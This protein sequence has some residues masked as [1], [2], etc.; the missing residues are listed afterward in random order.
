[1]QPAVVCQQHPH[2]PQLFLYSVLDGAKHGLGVFAGKAEG[3]QPRSCCS[4][5]CQPGHLR[6]PGKGVINRFCCFPFPWHR[7]PDYTEAEGN[8]N[9]LVLCC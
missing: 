4:S 8:Y 2:G 7:F 3:E 5:W 1:M 9:T 6:L